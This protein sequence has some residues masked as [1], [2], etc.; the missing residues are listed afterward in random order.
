MKN[1]EQTNIVS[2]PLWW[3]KSVTDT[4]SQLSSSLERGLSGQE[5]KDRLVNT[6]PNELVERGK[7]GPWRILWDQFTSTMI[8]VLIGAAVIAALLKDLPDAIAILAIVVLNAIL[9]FAQEFKAEKA[10]EAL[11]RLSAP[12]VR[13]R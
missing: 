5:V 7:K 1:R 8:L 9:G 10:L 3:T 13:V 12:L 2:T 11:K 6:G 4:V